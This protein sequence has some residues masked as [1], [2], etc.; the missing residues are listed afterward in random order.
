MQPPDR[1]ALVAGA[2]EL[3]VTLDESQ[4]TRLLDYLALL[5]KWNRVYNLTAVRQPADMLVQHLLD[6]IA[7][8]APLCR[9]ADVHPQRLLDVGSGAGLPGVVVATLLPAFDVTCVD[10]VGKKVA[11]VR[12]AGGELG[13]YNLHATHGRVEA[14]ATGL[15]DVVASRAFASLRDFTALTRP[16]MGP[17]SVWL[18]MK[19]SAPD[20]ELAELPQDI[21]VFHVEQ[22][23]VP[24]L[25]AKR[26]LV[27]MRLRS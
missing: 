19:A 7:I 21:D 16:H 2:A 15:F 12:Q 9:W 4:A 25:D 10:A 20:D 18:A 13:L 24:G 26:C 5:T 3:G 17:G 6:C 22:L 27:W 1:D 14:L 8:I 23:A 11:F